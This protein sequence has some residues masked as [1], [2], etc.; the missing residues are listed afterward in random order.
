MAGNTVDLPQQFQGSS[1][2]VS[3]VGSNTRVK[4]QPG[5][6]GTMSDQ[7]ILGDGTG[8]WVVPNTRTRI[9]GVFMVSASCQ[10]IEIPSA[11]PAPP[12]PIMV[13][14][15]DASIRSL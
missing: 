8:T 7:L 5:F 10:G 11:Q 1:P 12:V 3:M 6:L 2:G 14:T 4:G 15:G 9:L 13:V